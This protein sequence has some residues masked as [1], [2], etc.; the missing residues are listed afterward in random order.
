MAQG[1]FAGGYSHESAGL[2]PMSRVA[3]GRAMEAGLLNK[4]GQASLVTEWGRSQHSLVRYGIGAAQVVAGTEQAAHLIAVLDAAAATGVYVLISL[5][6]DALALRRLGKVSK[7]NASAE[8]M[9]HEMQGNI[10][11]VKDHPALAAYYGNCCLL[12]RTIH[13]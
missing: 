10:S 3:S 5:G 6:V 4:L 11:L 1:W 7:H 9:W 12:L 2:P 8:Q 13:V